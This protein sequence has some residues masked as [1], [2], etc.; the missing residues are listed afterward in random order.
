MTFNRKM[1]KGNPREYYRCGSYTNKGTTAC[2][3]H[4]ILEDAIYNQ[5]EEDIRAYAKLACSDEQ[6]LIDRLSKDN[7]KH[8]DKLMQRQQKLLKEKECRLTDIDLLVQS[9][10]EEKISG[11]VP[12]NIFKRMA[13]KYDDEQLT[14]ANE[15]ESLKIELADLKRNESDITSW[16]TQIRQCLSI[17]TLNRELVVELIDSIEISDVYEIDGQPQQD[18][19]ITYRFE[20]ISSNSKRAS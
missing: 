4:T 16:I 3:P 19:S 6:Q 1:Y 2:K 14:L 7:M 17:E 8:S 10:F 12:E 18:I 5:V 11:T 20:N 13:K 15:I 9:L